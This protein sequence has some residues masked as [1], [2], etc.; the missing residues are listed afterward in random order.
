[1]N[2][3]DEIQ[4][5]LRSMDAAPS[6]AL[7]DAQEARAEARRASI[8]ATDPTLREAPAN[9]RRRR[10]LPLTITAILA[11]CGIAAGGTVIAVAGDDRDRSEP[12]LTM[13]ENMFYPADDIDAAWIATVNDYPAP[14]PSGV[15]FPPLAPAIFHPSDI[16]DGSQ[17]VFQEGLIDRIATTYWKCAWLDAKI[18]AEQAED[19]N[20]LSE[21]DIALQETY[22]SLPGSITELPNQA[23]YEQDIAADAAERGI[24]VTEAEFSLDCAL[25][26]D[27]KP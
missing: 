6:S 18:Q 21:A 9:P 16:E 3:D 22:P 20:A 1:M 19:V 13:G 10:T 2:V 12:A 5:Q 15:T 11:A 24:T 26:L 17:P 7:T 4:N 14:L 8:L 23:A 27:E 25:Y